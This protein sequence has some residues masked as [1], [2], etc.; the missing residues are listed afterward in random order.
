M[1]FRV[2]AGQGCSS[3]IWPLPRLQPPDLVGADD[4][5][6]R[7]LADW[8]QAA[9]RAELAKS[10]TIASMTSLALIS[11]A[12]SFLTKLSGRT[13]RAWCRSGTPRSGHTQLLLSRVAPP[14][15]GQRQRVCRSARPTFA[16]SCSRLINSFTR[17]VQEAAPSPAPRKRI[18]L[19][20][21]WASPIAARL[22][23]VVASGHRRPPSVPLPCWQLGGLCCF[24]NA[25][26][27]RRVISLV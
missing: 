12:T 3:H 25:L 10:L 7:Q 21:A 8:H 24:T 2:R 26:S 27:D 23:W 20:W 16:A 15:L 14:L 22:G 1:V 4:K 18:S 6:F 17:A 9:Q 5:L 19:P 13:R 11:P